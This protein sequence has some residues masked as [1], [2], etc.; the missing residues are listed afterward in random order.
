VRGGRSGTGRWGLPVE[1]FGKLSIFDRKWPTGQRQVFT[2]DR[3]TFFQGFAVGLPDRVVKTRR[4]GKMALGARQKR[5]SQ[6]GK[7]GDQGFYHC[8]AVRG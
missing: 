2:L 8:V 4:F 3:V 6:F 5:E 7:R 1:R